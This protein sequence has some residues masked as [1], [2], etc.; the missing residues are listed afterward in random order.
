MRILHLLQW[1]V[2]SII[3]KLNKIK[4]QGFDAIQISPMQGTKEANEEFWVLY[5]PTNFKIG[6]SQIGSKEDLIKLCN[7]AH[8]IGIKVVVDVVFRHTANDNTDWLKP[9]RYIDEELKRDDFFTRAENITDHNDRW[10]CVNLST[11]LPMLDYRHRELQDIQIRYLNDLKSCGVGGF[12]ID[13]AKHF[14]LP[15][16]GCDYYDRVFKPFKD[17]VIYGEAIDTTKEIIDKYAEIMLV[18]TNGYGSDRNRIVA[19]VESHDEFLTWGYTKKL[20]DEYIN[21]EYSRPC[22]GYKN[23]LYYVRPFSNAWESDVVKY[24]NK[25]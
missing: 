15:S 5:Q 23:T 8:E 14:A 17:M 12:R 10:Q 4:E 11:E 22:E 13:M 3:P 2:K 21:S 9:N 6:N 1:N 7:K 20:S 19:W 24:A 25:K 16:E 18:A